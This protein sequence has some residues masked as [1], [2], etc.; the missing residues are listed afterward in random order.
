MQQYAGIYLL[1]NHSTCFGRP[2][3]RPS[4]VH[5][6]VTAASLGLQLQFYVHL[7]VGTM[8]TRN[9]YSGFAVNKY[10]HTVASCWSL[11]MWILCKGLYKT[12][13]LSFK[14][15]QESSDLRF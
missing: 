5:K 3:H 11:L 13:P 10:L 6:T 8:D 2:S 9:M 15:F 14:S 4:G 12:R 1:Q 7:M